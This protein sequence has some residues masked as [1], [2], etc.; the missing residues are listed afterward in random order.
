[1]PVVIMVTAQSREAARQQ[2][3]RQGEPMAPVLTKPMLACHGREALDILSRDSG[4]DAVLMDRQMP[5]MDGY[6]A[7]RL[8]RE[9]PAFQALPII[10]MTANAMVGDRDKALAAGMNDHIS[11]PIDPQKMYATL[12]HWIRPR[13]TPAATEPGITRSSTETGLPALPGIDI[14]A[15]LNVA[16]GDEALYLNLLQCFRSSFGDVEQEFRRARE[17]G[18]MTVQIRTAHTLSGAAGNIGAPYLQHAA[19]DLERTLRGENSA[20]EVEQR[21]QG[22]LAALNQVMSGLRALPPMAD[23]DKEP[24]ARHGPPRL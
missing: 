16:L 21:L 4:F 20:T 19:A 24:V 18:D 23:P 9:N 22:A 1:M 17:Q 6:S 12:A 10:A 3:I 13:A 11:K 8:I 2:A 7:T 5:V 14:A 15:G